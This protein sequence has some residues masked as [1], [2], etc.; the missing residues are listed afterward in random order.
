MNGKKM[1]S[2]CTVLIMTALLTGCGQEQKTSRP[3]TDTDLKEIEAPGGPVSQENDLVAVNGTV[4]ELEPGM[5]AV[6]FKG[7]DG[8]EEFLAQDG[9]SS[10]SEVAAYLTSLLNAQT[11]SIRFTGDAFGCSTIAVPSDDGEILFGRNFDWNRCEAWVVLSEPEQGYR[12]ISTVNTAFLNAGIDV[13]NLPQ[14]MQVAAA[15]YA[16]LDGM[17]EKG[18]AVSVNMIQDSDTIDQNTEKPDITTTTA[19]RLLLNKAGNVDEA[20]E[21]L[22]QYDMHASM[23]YM[24]HFVLA[25][26]AGN[27]AAV[28][29]VNN[30]MVV[31]DT[32]AV[33]NF[34]LAEGEK[35]GIGT[36][37]SHERYD[38][39]MEALA[40]QPA[41][42]MA[43][44]RDALSSVSKKNFN[45]FEST[46]WSIV[47]NLSTGAIQYYHRED[48]DTPYNFRLEVS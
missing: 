15:L 17:N 39:L 33:T 25:D 35:Q 7:N 14:P 9:A 5:S 36:S 43:D 31:I 29:Y 8:F 10:D 45:E 41:M 13:T 38:R 19:I 30:E 12:S 6:R 27:H 34:Y 37:Q 20:V 24:V 23:N 42:D 32:P 2:A 4:T 28:E 46:E 1:L 21:L 44:V 26:R 48:Y 22:A 3:G 11:G 18:L 40:E 16:P 47:Y